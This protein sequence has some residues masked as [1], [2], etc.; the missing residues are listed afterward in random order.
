MGLKAGRRFFGRHGKWGKKR[1]R[2]SLTLA[3]TALAIIYL[4]T[5]PAA[6]ADVT[7]T[8]HFTAADLINNQFANGDESADA[9]DV[10]LFA[11]ARSITAEDDQIYRTYRADER[12]QFNARWDHLVDKDGTLDSF[13]LWGLSQAAQW[14]EDYK[15]L[16]WVDLSAPDNW[17]TDFLDLGPDGSNVFQNTDE[18]EPNFLDYHTPVVPAFGAPLGD[19]IP[20]DA[21]QQTLKD[22][23]FSV[24]IEFDESDA[25]WGQDT[26]GAPN[27]LDRSLTMFWFGS[28]T[29]N[30]SFLPRTDTYEGNMQV[31]VPE[32]GTAVLV[33][34]SLVAL[35]CLG[36]S[37]RF[38]GILRIR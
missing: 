12:D 4:W 24:T 10:G 5:A 26:K 36:F 30:G 31:A 28:V 14:G 6:L 3:A 18:T 29:S 19:E 13:T 16:Q 21:D 2:H 7:H 38:R 9:A 11:G 32:P 15:P 37:Q 35:F 17:N 20:L 8:Y 23:K 25:W 22:I 33:I 1:I 34:W 27:Q